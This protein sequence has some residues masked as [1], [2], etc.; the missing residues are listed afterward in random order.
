MDPDRWLQI[1]QIFNDAL[2]IPV[3]KRSEFLAGVCGGD[4]ELER[5]IA[6][7]LS[8]NDGAGSFL[9]GIVSLPDAE[10]STLTET[11][12][13]TAEK[14]SH[15]RILSKIGAGG[16]GEVWLAEDTRLDRRVALK[17]LPRRFM[18]DP[19]L[20]HR[21][22]REA[23]AASMLNHPNIL[24]I[25]E[26]GKI[27]QTHF[28]ATE[29]IEG[30]TLRD[31]LKQG[32][33]LPSDVLNISIQIASAIQ[34]AHKAGIIHRDIKPDN[35]MIRPDGLIKVLDFGLARF[36]P[37]L[38]E[39]SNN[40]EKHNKLEPGTIPGMLVGTPRYMAPEQARGKKVDYRVDI[41]SIGVVMYEMLAGYPPFRGETMADQLAAILERQPEPL[42]KSCPDISPDLERI[43][44]KALA[45]N[46]DS[47]YQSAEELI[48]DLRLQQSGQYSQ[49]GTQVQSG[50]QPAR[51]PTGT[52]ASASMIATIREEIADS[53]R[54]TRFSGVLLILLVVLVAGYLGSSR[55]MG[56]WPFGQALQPPLAEAIP[57][58]EIGTQAMRDG[59]YE[60]AR[61]F[62][63]QA[64]RKDPKFALARARL[65]EALSEQD[66]SDD[67]QEQL[68]QVYDLIPDRSKLSTLDRL[69]L[70]AILFSVSRNYSGAIGNY[71]RMVD[72][73]PANERSRV[74][75]DLGRAYE[76]DYETGKAIE[77]Y[78]KALDVDP[79]SAAANLRLG[80]IYGER[81]K[82]LTKSEASFNQA[83]ALYRQADNKEGL[84]AV[85]FN[86]GMIYDAL[87]KLDVARQQLQLAIDSGS[88]YLA[89]RALIHL[90]GNSLAAGKLE[91]ARQE[92]DKGLDLAQKSQMRSVYTL[93]LLA[94]AGIFHETGEFEEAEKYFNQAIQSA[95]SYNG[96]YYTALAQNNLGSLLIQRGRLDEGI[97]IVEPAFKFFESA[98]YRNEELRALLILARAKRLKMDYG[99][100]K[101]SYDALLPLARKSGDDQIVALV[102]S[103]IS[104]LFIFQER[105]PQA[106]EHI[107]E[108]Y[109]TYQKLGMKLRLPYSLMRRARV[110]WQLGDYQPARAAIKEAWSHAGQS[111]VIHE[112]QVLESEVLL[113]QGNSKEA[114]L[115]ST[116]FLNGIKLTYPELQITARRIQG[117]S[118]ALNGSVRRAR[119]L[120]LESVK[121]ARNLTD[122]RLLADSLLALSQIDALNA[123][124]AESVSGATE[125]RELYSR[126][127]RPESEWRAWLILARARQAIGTP[128]EAKQS[129]LAASEKLKYLLQQWGDT[130]YNRYRTRPDI[131]LQLAQLD[132][133]LAEK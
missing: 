112:L 88:P 127:E 25:Y 106:T 129:A 104:Q 124:W 130:S 128:L 17:M 81:E 80:V 96:R 111:D 55:W 102:H 38:P 77:S 9:S 21:F 99:G 47:R 78:Q 31:R 84:A 121:E 105:Y 1:E 110:S 24:T 39:G 3:E 123:N 60:Q 48:N 73:A 97:R 62:L 133:L 52:P 53:T 5:E 27:G 89:T 19:D 86:R 83:E 122:Q 100:A 20:L 23:K 36:S 67:A 125:A 7:L 2:E 114:E 71:S 85:Y 74:F 94:K 28:I 59:S 42:K 46:P 58:Y 64:V 75:L 108:S 131:R 41:F 11:L 50:S 61:E 65:A 68:F 118:M 72:L 101:I 18:G 49:G 63:E 132:A 35:I 69:N 93:G 66:Y 40:Q 107:D 44:E 87:S 10:S 113:S 4:Q 95:R 22:D 29:Y 43:V 126:Q 91:Q 15:F 45:K 54:R 12:R 56:W 98:R 51:H 90:S 57:W 6:V 26:I 13:V 109:R 103:E 76:K 120:C 79:E 37:L 117:Q 30:M 16:M 14:I 8:S 115:K 33:F 82:D 92:V 119:Q 70:E 116:A 34:A 32:A